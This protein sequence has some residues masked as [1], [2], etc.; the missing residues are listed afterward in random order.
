VVSD[1]YTAIP[2]FPATPLF[3]LAH[4]WGLA[5]HPAHPIRRWLGDTVPTHMVCHLPCDDDIPI[6]RGGDFLESANEQ[7]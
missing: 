5:E 6:E 3:G 1:D 2:G 7:F 4:E